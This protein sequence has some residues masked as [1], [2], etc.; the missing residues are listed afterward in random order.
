MYLIDNGLSS[1]E[2]PE[3]G[4]WGGRYVRQAAGKN[5]FNDTIDR[6]VGIDGKTYN[7]RISEK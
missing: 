5:F 4:S 7:V 2:N 1:P 3:F 6:V